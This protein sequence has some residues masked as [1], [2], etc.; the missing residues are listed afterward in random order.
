MK[1]S[2]KNIRRY[3][4]NLEGWF[5]ERVKKFEKDPEYILEGL[6][7]ELNEQILE[8]LYKKGMTRKQL[9]KELGVS[10]AYITKL[11]NGNP[12]L[13][14][15]SLVKI[16]TVMDVSLSINIGEEKK[17]KYQIPLEN[18]YFEFL[19]VTQT[20]KVFKNEALAA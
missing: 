18:E 5:K 3:A 12:N 11:L 1:G 9:A 6:M 16:A 2:V 4:M 10:P 8:L 20:R 17:V 15:K 19:E 7:L 14:L 13:T